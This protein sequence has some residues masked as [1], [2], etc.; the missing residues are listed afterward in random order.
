MTAVDFRDHVFSAPEG[1]R[2]L[3]VS[4]LRRHVDNETPLRVLDLGCGTGAQ[5]LDVIAEFPRAQCVG[6]DISAG[7]IARANALAAASP[8]SARPSFHCADYFDF[9]CLPFDVILADSV[10]Q[11]LPCSTAELAGKIGVDLKPQGLLVTSIPYGCIYNHLLWV[12]RRCFRLLRGRLLER[13]AEAAARVLHP[14]WPRELIRERIPYLYLLPYRIDGDKL[15]RTF[16][17]DGGL[18]VVDEQ[19]VPHV[20]LAQPKHRMV[21]FRK[22]AT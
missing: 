16:Q 12:A 18:V 3:L 2:R 7:N 17:A 1:R 15:R 11:N 14:S 19:A 9:H 8:A 13:A 6:V 5:L 4:V 10:L 22:Q 20:S 21:V